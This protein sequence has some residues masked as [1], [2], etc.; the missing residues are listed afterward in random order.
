MAD[1]CISHLHQA[2]CFFPAHWLHEETEA[3]RRAASFRGREG[4]GERGP[5]APPRSLSLAAHV[6]TAIVS[7]Q[8]K[9]THP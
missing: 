9:S 6:N 8:D 4:P 1:A 7:R 3:Q 5:A 2:R